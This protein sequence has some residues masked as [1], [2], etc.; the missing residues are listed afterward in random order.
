MLQKLAV[1]LLFAA[2]ATHAQTVTE[3]TLY[4]FPNDYPEESN[5]SQLIQAQDGNFYGLTTETGV[6]FKISPSGEY[7]RIRVV[8]IN[9][10]SEFLTS[11]VQGPDGNFYAAEYNECF[12][13]NCGSIIK[14]TPAGTVTQ[15][16]QFTGGT[17]GAE[18]MGGLTIGSDGNFYGATS[19]GGD[20]SKCLTDYETTG[21]GTIYRIT[22]SGAFSVFYTF[23]GGSDGASPET[24][25]LEGSDGNFYGTTSFA[26]DVSDCMEPGYLPGCG[27]I[28]QLTPNQKLNTVYT[29]TA[30]NGENLPGYTSLTEGS[31]SNYYGTTFQGGTSGVGLVYRVTPSGTLSPVYQPLGGNPDLFY[32]LTQLWPAGNDLFYETLS[33]G[34]VFSL[35]NSGGYKDIYHFGQAE[36]GGLDAVIAGSDGN[37]YGMFAVEDGGYI[38]R[39]N[40]APPLPAPVQVSLS[41]ATV[42]PGTPVTISWQVLNAFSLTMQQCYGFETLMGT[43][44]PLG[45]QSGTYNSTTTIYS[46]SRT[47]TPSDVG[48]Y[49]YALTCGGVESGL[50]TLNVGATT[51]T[52]LA[53]SPSCPSVGQSVI[54]T[55]QITSGGLTPT[56]TVT[57]YYD[58]QVIRTATLSN[59]V[60]SVTASTN[61]LPPA[62]YNITAKYSGDSTYYPTSS[63][64]SVELGAAPTATTLTVSPTSVTPPG[65]VTL[66]ATVDRSAAGALGTPTG[67]VT[68]YAN[69]KY[70]LATGK[71]DARGVA[72]ITASS[73]GYPANTYPITAKYLGD[74]SDSAS[75]SSAVKVTLSN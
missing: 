60:A 53:A 25:L 51:T 73:K 43:M 72:T 71:L 16:Y 57:F 55:A 40:F 39:L 62:T 4:N 13:P 24:S 74:P 8:P 66:T 2:A 67:S 23:N 63:T 48:T 21:C 33:T 61:G 31:D 10:S 11:L 70:A 14:L 32:D 46:G 37:L 7:T 18:P 19:Q 45:K 29:F 34:E 52:N 58:S 26:G 44:T 3:T 59:G 30:G 27:T 5:F 38:Y 47:F 12:S 49:N 15:L 50:A 1:L 36:E 41:S 35:T 17:D 69:G 20:T 68:F 28:F 56:G 6:F 64:E 9:V 22:P 75:T 42:E 54:L 65:S